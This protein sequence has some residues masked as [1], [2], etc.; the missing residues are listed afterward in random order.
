MVFWVVKHSMAQ[1]QILGA[2]DITT[3][4]RQRNSST[5]KNVNRI[6]LDSCCYCIQ[7]S[8]IIDN[9]ADDNESLR[10]SRRTVGKQLVEPGQ[11]LVYCIPAHYC[12]NGLSC[13]TTP[14]LVYWVVSSLFRFYVVG[15][16]ET[17]NVYTG[18]NGGITRTGYHT[19]IGC[20]GQ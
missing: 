16:L 20:I 3:S 6:A 19:H 18:S 9:G 4:A 12:A 11:V 13:T 1:A 14:Q 17:K 2:C 10:L 7:Y 8:I 5:F 15:S